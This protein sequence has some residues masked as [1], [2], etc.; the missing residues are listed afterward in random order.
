MP[1]GSIA[2]MKSM[3]LQCGVNMPMD[4]SRVKKF[5]DIDRRRMWILIHLSTVLPRLNFILT[6]GAGRMYPFMSEREK[7]FMK[8]Q[9]SSP[10]NSVPL[11]IMPFHPK[12]RK[13]G[14]RTDSPLAFNRR[15]IYA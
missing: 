6:T 11:L 14:D 9:A 12:Q 3:N 13:P 7:G 5:Q 15:W 2:R 8:K 1:Y 4:G 10:F